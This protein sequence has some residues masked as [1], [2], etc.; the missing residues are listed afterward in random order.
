MGDNPLV[1]VVLPFFNAPFLGRAIQS[2]LDQTFTNF[3]LILVNNASTDESVAVAHS[4]ADNDPRVKLVE[5]S[6]QGVVFAANKGI[7]VAKGTF[8]M[9][10]DAD[11]Y[12]YPERMAQQVQV[13][14]SNQE[15]G[16]VSGL[17][18][19]ETE[20]EWGEGFGRYVDWVNSV[21]TSEEIALNQFVEFPVVNPSLMIR[22]E[23]FEQ[24]GYFRM[25]A[26]PEDYELF[27]R[28]QAAGVR[29]EKV[30]QLVLQWFDSKARLTRNDPT[31]S[32]EAFFKVKAGYLAKWLAKY[33]P[34]HPKV[35]VWGAGRV[36]RRRSDLLKGHGIEIVSYIDVADLPNAIHYT[37]IPS[38][39]TC[40]VVSYVNNRGAREEI[41]DFL[42][43]KEYIEGFHFILAS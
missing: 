32:Q 30:E 8:I 34:L 22:R 11:D 43:A 3:E 39:S 5:E 18:E 2:I 24:H 4:F 38:A 36:S 9:R 17:I 16:V 42:K 35:L 15:T 13:L 28:L 29:M 1:S 12:S 33:N 14:L 31:Y 7:K 20:E 27:L 26:F 23:L 41:R 40:F 6:Q 37:Q 19:Y 10:M 25:G 21:R